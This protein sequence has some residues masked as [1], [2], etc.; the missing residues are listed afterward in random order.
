MKR[1]FTFFIALLLGCGGATVKKEVN[2][3]S[4]NVIEKDT[5]VSDQVQTS[6]K[7]FDEFFDELRNELVTSISKKGLD[8]TISFCKVKS[9]ELEKKY[10]EKYN[11]KVYRI[12][13][14]YRNPQ[15]KPTEDEKKILEYWAKRLS[16]K[17]TIQPVYYVTGEKTK[18]MKPIKTF[19]N[20]CLQCHGDYESIDPKVRE[21][22]KKEYPDDKAFGYK[23]DDLRGAFVA[24][25]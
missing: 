11:R 17:Q 1:F 20:L 12:S 9:L 2:E 24:E 22:I 4:F 5:K 6:L 25:F 23:L 13:D 21:A 15:H 7:A 10:S 19:A 18:V 16:E 14:K 8:G 3:I